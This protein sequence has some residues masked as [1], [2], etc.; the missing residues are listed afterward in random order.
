MSGTRTW[1]DTPAE[2]APFNIPASNYQTRGNNVADPGPRIISNLIVDQ[3]VNNPAAVDAAGPGAEPDPGSG[4]FFIPN[5]TPDGGLSAPYNS[6]FTLFGQFFDHGL[7][8]VGKSATETVFV[9]LQADDPLYQPGAPTNF[10][11]VSRTILN[12]A[13]QATNTTTPYV[14]QNQT[15]T[16]HSSHQVFLREYSMTTGAPVAT[17]HLA[18][19]T[20]PGN[21]AN[22][23]E[24]KAN[25]A[26]NL[27]IALVDTDVFNVPLLVTDEYGRFLPGPNGFPQMVL[28][29]DLGQT[30]RRIRGSPRGTSPVRAVQRRQLRLSSPSGSTMRSS[31]TSRTTLCQTLTTTQLSSALTSSPAMVEATRTSASRRSTPSSTRSTTGWRRTSTRC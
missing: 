2:G 5:A 8:L 29:Q 1:R 23:S 4:S 6:L 31:T 21:I 19:G 10:M 14:D 24:T 7:D 12:G 22:W 20:I 28:T 25:A 3:S 27:G 13:G 16:S 15:Y 9:P 11:A 18:D 17:G 30:A 26:S